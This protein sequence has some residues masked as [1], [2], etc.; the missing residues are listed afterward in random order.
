[1]SPA[2]ALTTTSY[3]VLG[4]LALRGPSTPY[5]LKTFVKGSIGYFW[6]FPHSQLY[7]EPE[8]LASA[9]LAKENREQHGRRRRTFEITEAGRKALHDWL[10]TPEYRPTEIRDQGILKLFF[11]GL[12]KPG[13]VESPG[14]GAGRSPRRP[15]C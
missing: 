15:A 9:G 4:L 6:T 8:R 11:G 3:L 1:M 2:P 7:T 5:D 10:A 14:R 13:E 12:L